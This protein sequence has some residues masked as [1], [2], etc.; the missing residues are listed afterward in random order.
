VP[1]FQNRAQQAQSE[2]LPEFS[3]TGPFGGFQSEVPRD[4]IEQFGMSNVLN[5]IFRLA[6]VGVR[7]GYTLLELMPDPQEAIIGIA[8]FFTV[9]EVRTQTI[10]TATRLMQYLAGSFVE[11]TATTPFTG[12]EDDFWNWTVV[13]NQLLFSNNVDPV[14]AWDGATANCDI[15]SGDAVACKFLLELNTHLLV[16]NTLEG[17]NRFSQR[18]R[19]T[20]AGDPTDW[21]G[22]NAGVIDIVN[23]LGPITGLTKL[24]QTG[25]AFHQWGITQIIPTGIG[26]APFRFIPMT[27]KARGN[28]CPYSVAS[29]GEE[30]SAYVGKD[31]I[32]AFNGT[33]S[34]PI[35]DMPVE[36]SR[37]RAGAR[38]AI[39]ADVFAGDNQHILGYITENVNGR[40]FSAYWLV[41]PN[42]AVWVYNFDE[43]NWTRFNYTA[44]I[45]AIGTFY[46]AA[47][48]RIMD[49]VGL[50]S[51]QNWTPDT[52]NL[53]NPFDSM[54][55]GFKDG[56]PAVVDF[57]N[58][59]EEDWS[60]SGVHVFGD[61]RHTKTV[62]T[63]RI[64]I[65]DNG[66][67]TFTVTVSNQNGQSET[68]EVTMGTGSGKVLSRVL[69]FNIPGIRIGWTVSGAAG[70][71]A[72]FV[73]FSPIFVMGGE[74]RGGDVDQ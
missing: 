42:V 30:L 40:N 52:L 70:E 29:S 9:D 65:T 22:F 20:A 17:G 27:S 55:L 23:N 72:N 68:Q 67:T 25:Y 4:Q 64:C 11:I 10:L 47:L 45:T 19:W 33:A 71:P 28:I 60:I 24:Y 7:P 41:I 2:E 69:A 16:A 59:S 21:V 51:D 12:S 14:Y 5:M 26:T 53:S 35:G 13:N 37:S 31:N 8:D 61:R 18:V 49:L 73:E 63:F 38:T 46:T 32:Y 36:G 74:Q 3:I 66:E 50:I 15:V 56:S 43:R 54:M 1:A 44:W 34:E 6:S 39:F 62:K 57:T 58:Y 48:I